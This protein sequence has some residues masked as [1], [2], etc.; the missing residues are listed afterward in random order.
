MF[1]KH[2][3]SK[4]FVI[5]GILI[6]SF[7]LLGQSSL[8][9]NQLTEVNILEKESKQNKKEEK[10]INRSDAELIEF[11]GISEINI[12]NSVQYPRDI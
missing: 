5:G 4:Y 1:I 12:D 9:N 2:L 8:L 10:N 3:L 6:I 11:S 7:A